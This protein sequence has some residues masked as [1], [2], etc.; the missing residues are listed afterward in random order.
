M[1]SNSQKTLKLNP[2]MFLNKIMSLS[3]IKSIYPAHLV[4]KRANKSFINQNQSFR[5]IED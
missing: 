3:I 5:K 2:K 4:K 1:K